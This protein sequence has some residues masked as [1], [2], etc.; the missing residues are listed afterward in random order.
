[1][2]YLTPSAKVDELERWMAW[3]DE[4]SRNGFTGEAGRLGGHGFVDRGILPLVDALNAIDGVCTLQSCEGHTY[5]HD[6]PDDG[7]RCPDCGDRVMHTGAQIWL[8]LSEPLARRFY[9]RAH[10]LAETPLVEQVALLWG[11]DR[12]REIV[13]VIFRQQA[14]GLDVE[15]LPCWLRRLGEA[16]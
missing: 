13:D 16:C 11:R 7:Y 12:E 5:P 2:R 15:F 14:G 3:R 9:E 4:A 8:W 1:M 6:G 10:E